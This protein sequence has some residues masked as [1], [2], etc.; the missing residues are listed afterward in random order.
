MGIDATRKWP[1]EGFTREWPKRLVTTDAGRVA[2][3]RRSGRR[4]REDRD[5]AVV[6]DHE[7]SCRISK[8]RAARGEAFSRA[9]AERVLACADL[10]AS[11]CSARRRARRR[12]GDRVTFGR[13]CASV[14]RR[15]AAPSAARRAK[16]GSIGAPASVDEARARVRGGGGRWPPACR[17]RVSRS[18]DLL[19]AR[20]RRSP[21]AG[22]SRARAARGRPRGVAEVPLDRLGDTENAIEVVRAVAHGGLGVWRAT[23][24]RARARRPARSDRARRGGAA[25]D[26]RASRRSRRCRDSIRDD[27]PSTG[28]DDVRT[29]AVA[30]LMCRSIPSIQVD[31]PL[32][33]PKLAQVAIAY[34]ADD[35]DGVAAVDT[36]G[37]RAAPLAAAKTSSGRFARRSP[38]RR[39][40]TA[41]SSRG[42]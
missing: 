27:T 1:S 13:V 9:D 20:R 7:S 25:R 26:R 38:N 11:A 41:G 17:S 2:R 35:L 18:R 22:G 5:E 6:V 37:P 31:W 23:I 4:S 32:Y 28:Y 12:R 14:R 42:S 40:A 8:S 34:G 21:G 33:G 30:R 24:D 16:C 39:S 19:D 3:P 15:G 36:L 10:V 29:I